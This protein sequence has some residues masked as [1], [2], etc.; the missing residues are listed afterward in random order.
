MPRLAALALLL[1]LA[2][3]GAPPQSFPQLDYGYLS[4]LPLDVG[5]VEMGPPWAP[6]GAGQHV[7]YLAPEPPDAVLERMART[8]LIASGGK[9]YARV[10]VE[11]A[12]IVLANTDYDGTMAL[13]VAIHDNAGKTLATAEAR[14]AAVRPMTDSGSAAQR[15]D[16]YILTKTLMDQIN[17]ELEYQVRH[18]LAKY[19]MATSA[20]APAP[21]PVQIQNLTPGAA[22]AAPTTAGAPAAAAPAAGATLPSDAVPGMAAPPPAPPAL[23]AH[24]LLPQGAGTGVIPEQKLGTLPVGVKQIPPKTKP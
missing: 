24:D 2:A 3:C 5:R 9:G 14:V 21:G 20:T 13:R 22:A 19:L 4:R 10:T 8:R 15:S 18:K 17:V 12:S 6:R 23:G 1:L 16:L 11:D 7:E